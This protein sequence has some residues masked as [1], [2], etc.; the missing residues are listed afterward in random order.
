MAYY[1]AFPATYQ[2]IYPAQQYQAP[3]MQTPQ[4]QAQQAPQNGLIWV[5]GEQAAKSYLVAPNSTVQLWDS[6]EKVIYLKS[7][8][9]SGMPSMKILDYT[10]RGDANQQAVTPVMEYATK[11]ELNQLAD[12]LKDLREEIGSISKRR[13]SRLMKEDDGD[14]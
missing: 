8:D 2:P 11:D 4:P 3:V 5:Q 12:K 14:E 13:S 6:E 9:A 10:I 1:G 7:A